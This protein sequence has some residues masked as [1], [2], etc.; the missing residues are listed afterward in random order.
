M[1]MEIIKSLF[2]IVGYYM[3]LFDIML[4]AC[5]FKRNESLVSHE[6]FNFSVSLFS[7]IAWMSKQVNVLS[8]KFNS[9]LCQKPGLAA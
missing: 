5:V 2:Q 1:L 9:L 6:C 3:Y 4:R 7:V 8:F